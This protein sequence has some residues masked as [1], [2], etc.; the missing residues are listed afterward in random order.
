MCKH[1][2]ITPPANPSLL[3]NTF[4][5]LF[6][7]VVQII[8]ALVGKV[9][10][11]WLLVISLVLLLAHTTYTTLK[12]AK[13][14]YDKETAVLNK[15]SKSM[16]VQVVDTEIEMGEQ[17]SMLADTDAT[18]NDVAVSAE[19][20]IALIQLME[21]E[22]KTPLDKV[23]ILS[24]MVIVTCGLNMLKGKMVLS[25]YYYFPLMQSP[26]NYLTLLHSLYIHS[27]HRW[28]WYFSQSIRYC[29][30][31]TIIL[32]DDRI[33]I[34]MDTCDLFMDACCIDRKME[35]E[36]KSRI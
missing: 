31:I 21:D 17:T 27:L 33:N 36:S 14:Q 4:F 1:V 2:L 29:M 11:D 22:A 19:D 28:W 20:Q 26:T 16:L 13:Q 23:M 25:H 12:K 18:Q 5:V 9:L 35:I 30:W 34:G 8:G 24:I 7:G 32:D 6:S 3:H 10:P 15:A